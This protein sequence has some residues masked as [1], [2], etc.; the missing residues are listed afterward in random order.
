[1]NVT[2]SVRFFVNAGRVLLLLELLALFGAWI[3]QLTGATLLG[4]A[5]QHLFND[6]IAL[7]LLAIGMF[8]DAFWHDR[9]V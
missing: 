4:M 3:T 6:A 2:T 8:L 7:A 5:Q 1:M 9:N